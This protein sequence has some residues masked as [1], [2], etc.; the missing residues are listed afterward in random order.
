MLREQEQPALPL[1]IIERPWRHRSTPTGRTPRRRLVRLREVGGSRRGA[2]EANG[3][4]RHAGVARVGP[5]FC[6]SAQ[7]ESYPLNVT[8][9]PHDRDGRDVIDREGQVLGDA[10]CSCAG[11]RS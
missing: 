5:Q 10:S 4:R 6:T 11:S 1:R 3:S 8:V 2:R 9:L 7:F